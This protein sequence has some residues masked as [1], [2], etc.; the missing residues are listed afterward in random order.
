MHTEQHMNNLRL[1]HRRISWISWGYLLLVVALWLTLLIGGD[2]WWFATMLLFGPRW[3]VAIPLVILLPLAA[4][5]SR[6]MLIP[7]SLGALVVFGP[8]MGLCLGLGK[9]N[10][11]GSPMLRVLT[12]NIAS[13]AIHADDLARLIQ[14]THADIV[15]LQECPRDVRS[16][17]KLSPDWNGIQ[18]GQMAIFSRYPLQQG[19]SYQTQHP[20]HTWPRTSLLESLIETPAGTIAF[21]TMHLPSPRFG[22]QTMLD[23]K[24]G[25]RFS[26]KGLLIRETENRGQT[27]REVRDIIASQSLPI[28]VAGDFN[29]PADSTIY[30]EVWKGYTNAFTVAALGYGWTER[31]AIRGIPLGIRIDHIVTG[32]GF[33]IRNCWVGPYVGSDHLPLIAEIVKI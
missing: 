2:R 9:T 33:G 11:P 6:V 22:L 4:W 5:R 17:L 3:A 20:P 14:D 19:K 16:I 13:G 25:L 32:S 26:R 8:F 29:M 28:I 31:T 30:R 7:L 24:T 18:E 10:N 21:S 23:R 12:C 1:F 15:A 27:A